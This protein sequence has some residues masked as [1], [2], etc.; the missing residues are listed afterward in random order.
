MRHPNVVMYLGLCCDP[1]C[2]VTEYCARG[3][4]TDVLKRARNTPTMGVQLDWAR[5]LN[6]ALDAAKGMMYLHSS[7]PPVI[8]RDLKSPNLLVDKHWRVKVC[9]FNLSRVME[10]SVVLSSMAASNP[11]WLAPEILSG[12]GYTFAADVYSFGIIM[13]EF[14]TWQ[15]PWH[16]MGPWQVVAMVTEKALRPDIPP[17]EAMPSAG[18]HGL[19]QY[20]ALM[21]ACWAQ[22]P[23]ERPKFAEVISRLRNLLADEMT[24]RKEAKEAE[25]S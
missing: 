24:A 12:R 5:R 16:D 14:L 7:D 10:E 11:R 20:I 6:M 17:P 23:E 25:Y 15:V 19:P 3:S 13:W 22:N 18:F 21:Q 1:P 4:L 8:H 2:V 9:D